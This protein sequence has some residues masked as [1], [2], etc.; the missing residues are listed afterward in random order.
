M[1]SKIYS[2]LSK[3][4]IQAFLI[5]F[6]LVN[7]LVL[8]DQKVAFASN[9][10]IDLNTC[11]ARLDAMA[12]NENSY[13]DLERCLKFV[14]E[15]NICILADGLASDIPFSSDIYGV[16]R[17]SGDLTRNRSWYRE[18]DAIIPMSLKTSDW[19]TE[20]EEGSSDFKTLSRLQALSGRKAEVFRKILNNLKEQGLLN[21]DELNKKAEEYNKNGGVTLA[22]DDKDKDKEN[23]GYTCNIPSKLSWLICPPLTAVTVY[24]KPA[25][26]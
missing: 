12:R 26:D 18:E 2:Y 21:N 24:V 9:N 23:A 5:I 19:Q 11:K 22:K 10:T 8:L 14:R 1:L 15:K 16:Q 13:K 25:V 7:S 20:S 3:I 4:K 17:C 6:L